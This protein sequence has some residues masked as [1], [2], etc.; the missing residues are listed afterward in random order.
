MV[1]EGFTIQILPFYAYWRQKLVVPAAAHVDKTVNSDVLLKNI[2]HSDDLI[3]F[4][5]IVRDCH[6]ICCRNSCCRKNEP[7]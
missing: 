4:P 2:A 5:G 1:K 7:C 3:M 6:E